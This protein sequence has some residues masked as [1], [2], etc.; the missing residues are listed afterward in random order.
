MTDQSGQA[1]YLKSGSGSEAFRARDASSKS[2]TWES[3]SLGKLLLGEP[4]VVAA[5]PTETRAW[6]DACGAWLPVTSRTRLPTRRAGQE[7]GRP[8]PR[9]QLREGQIGGLQLGGRWVVTAGPLATRTSHDSDEELT[10]EKSM[11]GYSNSDAK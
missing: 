6:R 9:R 5:G 10:S 7:Q 8:G 11:G 2:H 4:E 1:A 3:A